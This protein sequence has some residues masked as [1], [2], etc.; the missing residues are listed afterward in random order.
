MLSHPKLL[1]CTVGKIT[2]TLFFRSRH[3]T[4]FT[5]LLKCN[6]TSEGSYF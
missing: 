5:V 4:V 3:S 6:N 2:M 1:N